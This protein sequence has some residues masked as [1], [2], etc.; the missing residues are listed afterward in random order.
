MMLSPAHAE[1]ADQ[2]IADLREALE[3]VRSG[4]ASGEGTRARYS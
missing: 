3:A 2:Y 1:V 4:Q